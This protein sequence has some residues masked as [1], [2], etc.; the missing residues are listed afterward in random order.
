MDEKGRRGKVNLRRVYKACHIATYPR[1]VAI[2]PIMIED[3]PVHGKVLAFVFGDQ[4]LEAVKSR[5]KAAS[6]E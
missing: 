2:V 4:S 6:E 3:H 5:K 1:T